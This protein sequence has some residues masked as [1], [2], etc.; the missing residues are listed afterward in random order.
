[1]TQH[2]PEVTP[3]LFWETMVAFQR[4]AALKTAIDLEI[5]TKIGEGNSTAAEIAS[6][7]GAAERGVR[8]LCDSLTVMG[9]LTKSGN[10]YALTD[11]SA[12]FLDKKSQMYIGSAVNFILSPQQRRGFDD[13]T[14][15]V[16]NGGSSVTGDASMDPESEMWV[17]FARSMAPLMFPTAQAV[18]EHVGFDIDRELKVL[19]VAAGHGIYGI[20]VGK[21]Y[22]NAQIYGADWNKVLTVAKEN[23]EKFG[24][25]GRYHTIGGDAFES[26]FGTGYD[27]IL[28]PNFLHHFDVP[29]CERFIRKLDASLAEGGKIMTVEFVP[30]D[31][32]VSPPPS[33]MFSIVMLAATPG[34]DAYTYPEL[35]QM[36]ENSGFANN[37]IIELHPMPQHLIVSTR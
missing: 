17:E 10:S 37:E 4:S 27:V 13:L 12:A 31:D 6:A 16:K 15:A 7:A 34:G 8:I 3:D 5:F 23:A 2:A 11:A 30:N 35:K 26:D 28:V 29:T 25:A 9:F 33:A 14:N 22:P 18:A 32:R 19:D 36:F 21:R 24:V 20:M 1:M